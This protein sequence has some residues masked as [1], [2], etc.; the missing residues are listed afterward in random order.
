M[1]ISGY[2]MVHHMKEQIKKL[3]VSSK[4]EKAWM[5]VTNYKLF[6]KK[7]TMHDV[8]CRNHLFIF[9]ST[10]KFQTS[11]DYNFALLHRM[12]GWILIFQSNDRISKLM[13]SMDECMECTYCLSCG[14]YY[15]TSKKI[16]VLFQSNF[17]GNFQRV[18]GELFELESSRVH[19]K[20]TDA[21][22]NFISLM[23]WI[24]LYK[25]II[26]LV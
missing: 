11:K 5:K 26:F 1:S 17:K 3:A 24:F 6:L 12:M 25:G 10:D 16:E 8:N 9:G 4:F 22:Y 18:L 14:N 23:L 7:V 21:S 20:D 13:T 19:N 15:D 2:F